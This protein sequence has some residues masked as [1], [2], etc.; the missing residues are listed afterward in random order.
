MV[1][2]TIGL[3]IDNKT[4]YSVPIHLDCT[5]AIH[6]AAFAGILM[7]EFD[8]RIAFIR[9]E[10]S[11]GSYSSFL[12]EF[13]GHVNMTSLLIENG[14]ALN[15]EHTTMYTPLTLA[16]S[17]GDLNTKKLKLT[18]PF[19]LLISNGSELCFVLDI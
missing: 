4:I 7:C 17:E 1:D 3:T 6:F 15:N 13:Q 14:A 12:I 2:T 9:I 10:R 19:L 8:F 16:A 18:K 11:F 5:T